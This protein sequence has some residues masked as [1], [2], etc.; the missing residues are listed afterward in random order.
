M[1]TR[2]LYTFFVT[3][4]VA[5]FFIGVAVWWFWDEPLLNPVTSQSAFRFLLELAPRNSSPRLVYGFLPY[6]NVQKVVV[7]PEVTHIGYFGLAIGPDG[8][9]QTR[10]EGNYTPGFV[11]LQ[12]ERLLELST[13]IES[14]GGTLELVVT[15]FNG[16]DIVA[17]LHSDAAQ[18]KFLEML[19]AIILA[20]PISG[21]NLDIE[22]SGIEITPE[23][24]EKLS[25]FVARTR[26]H[27]NSRYEHIPLSIDVYA[28]ASN[29]QQ[30]WDIPV[31]AEHVDYIVIMAYDYHRRSS[32]QAGPVAPLFGG[33]NVWNGDINQ[34]LQAFLQLAPAEKYLLGIPFYGYEWQTTD[35]TAQ[36]N[37][38]PDTGA[39]ATL[40]RV[41]E[42]LQRKE[43]LQVSEH[44]NDHA[45]SP[46]LSY[47]EDGKTYIIY[48]E[49]PRSIAYKID[50]VND[51]GLSGIAIWALGYESS[52][53]ALWDVI[54]R[55][56]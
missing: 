45:L 10:S 41:S 1:I 32:P 40:S 23:L 21:L 22:P 47:K 34:H 3:L 48:Y 25:N 44:W 7:Q 15:Q 52:D 31:L 39:T 51:L 46:Y 2:I 37:T 36:A 17:F 9:L 56:L 5:V 55:K 6:W 26:R 28:S 19:D 50:L 27:L 43:E 8:T 18:T 4:A 54:K 35:G 49:N 29:N 24:R 12:S 14:R 42:L 30:I 20:Y 33:D 16:N 13:D 11:A 38:Y 53:R